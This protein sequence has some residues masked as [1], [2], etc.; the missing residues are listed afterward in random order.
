[1]CGGQLLEPG[2]HSPTWSLVWR[3]TGTSDQHSKLNWT[4]I[5][6]LLQKNP[7]NRLWCLE[8]LGLSK[9]VMP[10]WSYLIGKS[11][12]LLCLW[13]FPRHSHW[14]QRRTRAPVP[15]TETQARRWKQRRGWQSILSTAFIVQCPQK[16]N[17][18]QDPLRTGILGPWCLDSNANLDT[19][20][21]IPMYYKPQFPDL[22]KLW[23][24]LLTESA[25]RNKWVNTYIKCLEQLTYTTCCI[26]NYC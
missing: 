11:T 9:T 12:Q 8:S 10:L 26:C 1:M 3:T 6:L 19:L 21:N 24:T 16:C 2:T 4:P 23:G 15:E 18:A 17:P 7:K 13:C 20:G 14:R 5:E 25:L 22:W